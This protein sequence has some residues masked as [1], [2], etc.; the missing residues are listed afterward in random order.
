[1]GDNHK[2]PGAK[3]DKVCSGCM[4]L[5][6]LFL[7]LPTLASIHFY[8]GTAFAFYVASQ[9]IYRCFR[10]RT[11][12]YCLCKHLTLRLGELLEKFLAWQIWP[13][14]AELQL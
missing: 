8:P 9:E 1:M 5:L 12:A 6:C 13:L 11:A 3:G 10:E 7:L 14:A 4:G 2:K